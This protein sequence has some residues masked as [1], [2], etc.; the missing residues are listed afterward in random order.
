MVSQLARDNPRSAL[1]WLSFITDPSARLAAA[2]NLAHHW[3]TL[4][5][6]TG[7][8]W[9]TKSSGLSPGTPGQGDREWQQTFRGL[10]L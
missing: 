6:E 4:D 1:P 9:L 10:H 8:A 3:L 5:P 2:K 7:H